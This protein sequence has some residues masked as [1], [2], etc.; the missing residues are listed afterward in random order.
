MSWLGVSTTLLI[1]KQVL[2]IPM[3]TNCAPYLANLFLH[4][5]E[6]RYIENLIRT[7]R[8]DQEIRLSKVYRYQDECIVFNDG[9][10][11]NDNAINIYPQ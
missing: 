5:S 11:F 10:L 7:E 2:G 6:A 8:S 9:R 4:C 1:F 3:G